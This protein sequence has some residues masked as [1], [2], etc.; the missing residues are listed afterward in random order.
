MA[1]CPQLSE[2]SEKSGL[3]KF[4]GFLKLKSY[5]VGYAPTQADI[6]V[7]KAFPAS[8]PDSKI[9]P[10]AARWYSHIASFSEEEKKAWPAAEVPYGTSAKAPAKP[11]AAE[12]EDDPFGDDDD[13]FGDDDGAAAK[14]LQ[15]KLKAEAVERGKRKA[16]KAR[17]LIVLEVKPFDAETN[18][19]EL[20]LNIKSMTHEGIQN[21]G[22]EHK[23][24]PV[25]FGIKKLI[26]SCVVHDNLVGMDDIIDMINDKY[27]DDIQS[28]DVQ[29][30]SKV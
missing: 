7:F 20:A 30:M 14:A 3:G 28:I 24:E 18:L 26:I 1:A 6:E 22:Q 10:H 11:K 4:N 12:E 19:E 23:L 5:I 29:S 15:E 16:A 13:L 9:A 21:W 25:A 8:G 2:L 27:E 17:S